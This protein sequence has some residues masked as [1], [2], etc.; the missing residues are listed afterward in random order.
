MNAENLTF[1]PERRA[2][3]LVCAA[4]GKESEARKLREEAKA[5]MHATLPK[6]I[7]LGDGIVLKL[8][9][10]L[11]QMYWE[12]EVYG[13]SVGSLFVFHVR[14]NM[15]LGVITEY[16]VTPL[17]DIFREGEDPLGSCASSGETMQ[18][19]WKQTLKDLYAFGMRGNESP[20]EMA[21]KQLGRARR[22]LTATYQVLDIIN[23]DIKPQV[24][25]D[26]E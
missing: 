11:G 3:N 1:G 7:D 21:S 17:G 8:G 6:E 22:E 25:P 20:M 13:S 24:D 23:R 4:A 9:K 14:I 15:D 26:A 16:V 10:E 12:Y 18:A 2:W 5:V 19:A